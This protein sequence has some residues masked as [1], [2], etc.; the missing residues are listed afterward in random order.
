MWIT[1]QDLKNATIS[2]NSRINSLEQSLSRF[3]FTFALVLTFM[4][5]V[6]VTTLYLILKVK[7]LDSRLRI[8]GGGMVEQY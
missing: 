7:N 5:A 4:L 1:V 2:N 3:D 8:L 6:L